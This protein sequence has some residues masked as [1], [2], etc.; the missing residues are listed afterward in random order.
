MS[1]DFQLRL[2]LLINVTTVKYGYKTLILTLERMGSISLEN[3]VRT[4][5]VIS[6][7]E[8]TVT[9]YCFKQKFV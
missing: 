3:T 7:L 5:P 4:R 6:D 9:K 1:R 2:K 8:Q